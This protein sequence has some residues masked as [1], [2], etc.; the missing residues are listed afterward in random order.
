[1]LRANTKYESANFQRCKQLIQQSF[2]YVECDYRVI[3][4]KS[5]DID[6]N[7]QEYKYIGG[8]L[9]NL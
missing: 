4:D 2:L 1:M 3:I 5:Y 7:K 8:I 6:R 9:V